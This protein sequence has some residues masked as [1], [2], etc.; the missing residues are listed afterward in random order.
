MTAA[1]KSV[2]YFG[3]YLYILGVTLI[4]VPN[5][6]LTTFQ[7]PET[8]EVWIRVVGVLALC[9]GFY[10]HRSG[11]QNNNAYLKL[12]VSARLF[13]FAAFVS[14]ALFKLVTPVIILFGTVDALGALWT[15]MALKK[16]QK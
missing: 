7:F 16:D 6:L 12:T 5:F 14:F 3:Y 8:N 2:C 15:W 11:I 4:F 10:Y 1:A 13:V 9:I